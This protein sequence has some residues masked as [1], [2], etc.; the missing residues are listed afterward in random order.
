MASLDDD[1]R[2]LAGTSKPVLVNGDTDFFSNDTVVVEDQVNHEDGPPLFVLNSP[3]VDS[4]DTY[5]LAVL[6][7]ADVVVIPDPLVL[8]LAPEQQGVQR[9]VHDLFTGATPSSFTSAF[10]ERP[11]AFTLE[12]GTRVRVFERT[13]PTTVDEA[14][15]ALRLMRR[16]TPAV[17]GGQLPWISI[18][19]L[20]EP[21]TSANADRPPILET[22]RDPDG[23]WTSNAMIYIGADE[24]TTIDG[25]V[26]FLDRSCGGLAI[27]VGSIDGTLGGDARTRF[28]LRPSGDR[29]LRIADLGADARDLLIQAEQL[30]PSRPCA[31]EIA[32]T[33]AASDADTARSLLKDDAGESP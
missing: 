9:I 27:T 5:P 33:A 29:T 7:G 17:P 32:L 11:E 20:S 1:L 22:G 8:S 19:G 31:T 25:E 13:R 14:T 18:G 30:D 26:E 10:R 12:D 28:E 16:Y 23:S 4:R 24:G 2:T 15:D 3:H 21:L 6:V